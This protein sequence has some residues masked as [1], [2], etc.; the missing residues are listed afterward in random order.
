[1]RFLTFLANF[2]SNGRR[3]NITSWVLSSFTQ[4]MIT[5]NQSKDL[6]LILRDSSS[7]ESGSGDIII[8]YN[9]KSNGIQLT[10]LIANAEK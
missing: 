2:R 1:M 5:R 9:G 10:I 3:V 7:K 4:R 8:K 6:D